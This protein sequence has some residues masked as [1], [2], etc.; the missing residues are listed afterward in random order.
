MKAGLAAW[1]RA[2]GVAWGNL[3]GVVL[4]NVFWLVC[5]W[6]VVTIGPATLAA[7][8]WA[9]HVL[10]DE[11][12]EPPAAFFGALKRFFW[13]GLGWS[14]A[15]VAVLV[16]AYTNLVV[17]GEWLP[18]FPAALLRMAWFYFLVFL[19][20]LQPFLLEMLTI[21]ERPFMDAV[22]RSAWQVAANPGYSHLHVA[23]VAAVAFVA[24][25][26]TTL[27]GIVLVALLMVWWA[28]AAVDV[29][30]RYGERRRLE[31]GIEDVL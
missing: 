23:I 20:A 11:Q 6:L 14:L 4:L 21:E 29:P 7:Y 22:K 26:T 28:V 24:W 8:W 1:K 25:Q 31:G 19:V 16:L 15:W 5:S 10:R 18:P 2:F 12:A 13:R 9:A 30:W 3:T 27:A 17:Y